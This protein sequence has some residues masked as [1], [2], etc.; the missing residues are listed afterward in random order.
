MPYFD[1][2]L[3]IAI[4]Q[5]ALLESDPLVWAYSQTHA[6]VGDF[7]DP[8]NGYKKFVTVREWIK[9][10]CNGPWKADE[11]ALS[12]VQA[13]ER[14]LLRDDWRAPRWLHSYACN[15]SDSNTRASAALKMISE[16]ETEAVLRTLAEQFWIRIKCRLAHKAKLARIELAKQSILRPA[17]VSSAT[18]PNLKTSKPLNRFQELAGQ[19][20]HDAR[21]KE[22]KRFSDKTLMKICSN[23]DA[24][25]IKPLS[26]LEGQCRKELADWNQHH[27]KKPIYTFVEGVKP[28]AAAKFARRGIQRALYRAQKNWEKSHRNF[29]PAHIADNNLRSP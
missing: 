18:P 5:A 12:S 14:S 25:K 7:L 20:M 9:D 4:A 10:Y 27:P 13:V 19:L 6:M 11:T 16:A 15:R 1:S 8:K 26:C 22:P 2:F 17:V 3:Q 23:L 24:Q 29:V 28:P 21:A